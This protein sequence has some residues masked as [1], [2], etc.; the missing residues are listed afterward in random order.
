MADVAN[1]PNMMIDAI[2]ATNSH[3]NR[4]MDDDGVLTELGERVIEAGLKTLCLAAHRQAEKAGWNK[5]RNSVIEELALITTEVAEGIEEAR[6][7]N[8][9]NRGLY[10]DSETQK[11]EGLASEVGDVFIRSAHLATNTQLGEIDVVEGT[12]AKLRFNP[13]RAYRHGGRLA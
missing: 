7:G 12:L 5:N 3:P 6:D 9:G 13:T 2:E 1:Y 10:Y 11:P 8:P 4:L